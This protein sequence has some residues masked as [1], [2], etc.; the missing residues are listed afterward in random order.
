MHKLTFRHYMILALSV[1]FYLQGAAQVNTSTQHEF[2]PL[3]YAYDALE[4][5]IDAQ[6]MELHYSKHHRGY[7]DNFI[8][9]ITGTEW[10]GRSLE[11][12]FASVSKSTAA[13]R[14][15][16]GGYYNHTLYWNNMSPK[17]GRFLTTCS[18]Q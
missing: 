17:P 14:N 12:I 7:Y 16:S 15:M 4:P 10:E 6:T 13:I 9:A 11:E 8:K 18:R 5:F 3:P 2:S 1:F